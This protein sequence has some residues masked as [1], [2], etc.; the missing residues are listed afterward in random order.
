MHGSTIGGVRRLY[1][2]NFV[3]PPAAHLLHAGIAM[4]RRAN[5]WW[6]TYGLFRNPYYSMTF[7]L[8][9]GSGCYR[10]ENDFTCQLSYGNVVITNPAVKQHF[11]PGKDEFWNDLLVSFN[12]TIFDALLDC[13]FIDTRTPVYRVE[14]PESWARRLE[15]L[16]TAARPSTE[17][18]VIHE[19]LGFLSFL[20]ELLE[21]AT[22]EGSQLSASDWFT[23]ACTM[24][25]NDLSRKIEMQEMARE[26]GMS[27]HTFR[28]YFSKRAGMPPAQYRNK[29]R[30]EA[31]CILLKTTNKRCVDIAFHFGYSSEQRFSMDFKKVIGIS[32]VDYRRR[33]RAKLKGK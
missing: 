2:E 5:N 19:A 20:R 25:T 8:E 12:G 1:F 18:G 17:T 33:H 24:L 6:N 22:P 7:V 11:G 21:N 27:Y 13:R 31:A 3:L 15:M 26:L 4:P 28:S 30:I 10:D 9:K 32:P 23:K 16:L 29:Q 14:D